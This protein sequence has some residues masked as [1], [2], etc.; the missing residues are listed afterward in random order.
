MESLALMVFIIWCCV[1]L[2]GPA[3]ALCDYFNRPIAAS[4]LALAAIWLGV[5]W[6]AHVFTWPRYLGLF[7]A[8]IGLYVVWRTAKR[9]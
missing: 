6:F 8:A 1:F 2:C 7:S 4:L 9:V 3:A 5:F